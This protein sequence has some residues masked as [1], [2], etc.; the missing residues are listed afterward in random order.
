MSFAESEK[1]VKKGFSQGHACHASVFQKQTGRD[2]RCFL[3]FGGVFWWREGGSVE[4]FH[5]T[6]AVIIA[7]AQKRD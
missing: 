6:T 5:Y 4:R 3:W 7:V 2:C 1:K